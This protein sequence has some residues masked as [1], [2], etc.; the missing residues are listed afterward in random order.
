MTN[1]NHEETQTSQTT[2]VRSDTDLEWLAPANPEAATPFVFTQWWVNRIA[3]LLSVYFLL[4]VYP[5][6][7]GLRWIWSNEVPTWKSPALAVVCALL[8]WKFA[9]RTMWRLFNIDGQD[10][11]RQNGAGKP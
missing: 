9:N 7:L 10:V 11:A 3:A 1:S 8:F 4:V 5:A 6:Y 2:D